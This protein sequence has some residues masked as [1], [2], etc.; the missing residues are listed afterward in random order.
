M[1]QAFY[2]SKFYI[3]KKSEKEVC[4]KLDFEIEISGG[5]EK[6]Y[7]VEI[8][9]FVDYQYLKNGNNITPNIHKNQNDWWLSY[10]YDRWSFHSSIVILDKYQSLGIGTFLINKMLEIA[11]KYVP[12]ARLSRTLSAVDEEIL[13]NHIRRDKLYKNLG[14][15]FN[16]DNTGFSI[17]QIGDLKI[18]KDF[19]YIQEVHILNMCYQLRNL[20]YEKE[21]DVKLLES[22]KDDIRKLNKENATLRTRN[23][24]ILCFCIALIFLIVCL[25]K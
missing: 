16:E 13:E 4:F 7:K 17:E 8:R 14:F 11:L 20:Q 21:G 18:R 2:T 24:F 23:K 6:I 15:I 22:Y 10:E 9:A 19:D 3:S 25:I 1:R 12:T 5:D